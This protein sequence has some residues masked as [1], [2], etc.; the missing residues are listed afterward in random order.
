MAKASMDARSKSVSNG[1]R[2]EVA[3]GTAEEAE[4]GVCRR[5]GNER[6]RKKRGRRRRMES[7]SKRCCVVDVR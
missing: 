1:A 7:K 6:S 2:A 5:K 3:G 4:E